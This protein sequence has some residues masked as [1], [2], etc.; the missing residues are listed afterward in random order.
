MDLL[1]ET[2]EVESC[3]AKGRMKDG[4]WRDRELEGGYVEG[5][6]WS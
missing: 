5:D 2:V 1:C 3:T 6:T 4:V